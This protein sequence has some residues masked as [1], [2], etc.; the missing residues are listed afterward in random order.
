M[1]FENCNGFIIKSTNSFVNRELKLIQPIKL[2][3]IISMYT[4]N[5]ISLHFQ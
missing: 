3:V 5:Q 2:Y 4:R 1:N